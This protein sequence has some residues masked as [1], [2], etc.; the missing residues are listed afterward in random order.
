MLP[1]AQK[2]QGGPLSVVEPLPER[3][4]RATQSAKHF[5]STPFDDPA[6]HHDG[7]IDETEVRGPL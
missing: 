3:E 6:G 1:V 5:V 7:G 4:T 2:A